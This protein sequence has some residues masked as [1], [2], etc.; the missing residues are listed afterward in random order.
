[1]GGRGFKVPLG[2]P[3]REMHGCEGEW[4]RVREEA[5]SDIHTR[6][7]THKNTCVCV[8]VFVCVCVYACMYVR[9][10]V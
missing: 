6:T 10:Y 3:V 4:E 1:M 2:C 9:M 5:S 7:Q 8:C